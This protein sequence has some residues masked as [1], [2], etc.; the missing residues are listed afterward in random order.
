MKVKTLFLKAKRFHI[1]KI[2]LILQRMA[3]RMTLER[4]SIFF[5]IQ[6]SS[7]P[8]R[9]YIAYKKVVVPSLASFLYKY[10]CTYTEKYVYIFYLYNKSARNQLVIFLM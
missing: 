1:Y 2:H 4:I 6:Y 8:P 7:R 10:K 5:S 9:Y 3:S